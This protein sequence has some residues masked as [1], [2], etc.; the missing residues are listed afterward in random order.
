MGPAHCTVLL[1]SLALGASE[2]PAAAAAGDSTTQ[3]ERTAL[4]IWGPLPPPPHT[5]TFGLLSVLVF[6]C[7]V[8][9]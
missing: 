7:V 9:I 3:V 8:T 2:T 6:R 4:L 1:L 5:H